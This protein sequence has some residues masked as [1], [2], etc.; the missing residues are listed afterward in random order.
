VYCLPTFHDYYIF[1][2]QAEDGIRDF[3][4]TGVQTCALPILWPMRVSGIMP[5]NR[6][7]SEPQTAARVTRTTASLGCWIVGLGFSSTRILYGPRYAM[8]LTGPRP[9]GSGLPP[10]R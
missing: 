2:C 4:V 8:A 1:F 7:R 6:W 3:H 9:S 10:R 5:W